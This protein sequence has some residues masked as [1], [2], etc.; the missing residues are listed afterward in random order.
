MALISQNVFG[1]RERKTAIQHSAFM[2]IFCQRE[3][4]PIRIVQ[5]CL[6]TFALTLPAD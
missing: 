3:A 6:L 4:L 5:S 2:A 1:N